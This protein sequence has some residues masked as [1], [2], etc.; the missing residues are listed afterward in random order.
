MDATALREELDRFAK[1]QQPAMFAMLEQMVNQD[2]GSFDI[3]DVNALGDFLTAQ[4]EAMG[5]RVKK[6]PNDWA[7]YPLSALTPGT[8]AGS[9]RIVLIGHRDT[10]FPAGT[11]KARPFRND[12]EKC[13]GPGVADMKGGIVSG[14]F[15]I[16]AILALEKMVGHIPLEIVISSDEEI[17]SGASAPVLAERARNAR[18][19]FSFEPARPGRAVVTSR[20]GGALFEIEVFGKAAH[21]GNN[22]LDGISAINALA[23][24]TLRLA[25]LSDDPAGMNANVGTIQGGS[26]AI[27]VPEHA[28]AKVYMRFSTLDQKAYL[29]GKTREIIEKANTGGIKAVMTEPVGFLPFRKSDA[30]TALF[31]LVQEAGKALGLEVKGIDTRG[32]ADSGVTASAGV[33]TI[34]GMGPIGAN[35]HTDEEYMVTSSL[36]EQVKLLAMSIIMTS[37]HLA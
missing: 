7:G 34:C 37:E 16:K 32:P 13:R 29:L 15:A 2:S 30:N 18:A 36:P 23:A 8:D 4:L 21:A 26:G 20:D 6:Y 24:I 1:T 25:E 22:F 10:V 12:G 14:I 17:G 5:C 3:G 35:L 31:T 27:V 28:R 11:A 33:P 9:R 19:V